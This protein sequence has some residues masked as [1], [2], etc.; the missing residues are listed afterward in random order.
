MVFEFNEHRFSPYVWIDGLLNNHSF[1]DYS[2]EALCGV[3]PKAYSLRFMND[4]ASG[5][6]IPI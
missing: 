1:W 4:S 5:F 3:G 6:R 2:Q